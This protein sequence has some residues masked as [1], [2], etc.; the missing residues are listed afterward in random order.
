MKQTRLLS[1]LAVCQNI[2]DFTLSDIYV[3]HTRSHSRKL[4]TA[5]FVTGMICIFILYS[6][7]PVEKAAEQQA[8]EVVLISD[9]LFR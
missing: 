4:K 1:K 3:N 6:I 5:W 9:E 7:K 8:I 2:P